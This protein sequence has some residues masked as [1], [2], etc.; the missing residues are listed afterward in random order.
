[1][2]SD[3]I[4]VYGLTPVANKVARVLPN[5][6]KNGLRKTYK[7]KMKELNVAGK[8]E[9]VVSDPTAPTSLRALAEMPDD[10]YQSTFRTGQEIERSLS[11]MVLSKL[12]A[13]LS[14]AR[15]QIPKTSWDSSVLGELDIPE[16]KNAAVSVA[17]KLSA[18]GMQRTSSHLSATGKS[19]KADAPRPKRNVKKRGYE[20]S[21]FEGY[22]EGYV[23]DEADGGYTS[24]E[25]DERGVSQKRRKK[26]GSE[27]HFD[28]FLVTDMLQNAANQTFSGPARHGSYGPGMVGA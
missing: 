2:K 27:S 24:G 22:G 13:A 7:G 18:P 16:T 23:D 26:V 6:E 20:E 19:G 15:G 12:P 25:G 8:F 1:M 28:D 11:Q 14:M 4:G 17:S 10:Y 21:S 3:L 5:G 9:A